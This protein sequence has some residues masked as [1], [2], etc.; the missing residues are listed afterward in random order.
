MLE[1]GDATNAQH[2][3]PGPGERRGLCDMTG[4]DRD[5]DKTL[6]MKQTESFRPEQRLEDAGGGFWHRA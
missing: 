3:W 4:Q 5:W 1:A 2:A 6:G